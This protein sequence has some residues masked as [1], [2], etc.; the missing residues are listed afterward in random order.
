MLQKKL[1]H[2]FTPDQPEKKMLCQNNFHLRREIN[3]SAETRG[4]EINKA[5]SFPK[6]SDKV[7]EMCGFADLNC[8]VVNIM[9]CHVA[10]GY[11]TKLD[12]V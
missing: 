4:L 8:V 9:D 5:S 2:F 11:E 6:N 3:I 7:K 10:N 1:S 12:K